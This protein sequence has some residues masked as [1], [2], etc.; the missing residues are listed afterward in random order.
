[1]S[2]SDGPVD[3]CSG[4]GL[5]VGVGVAVVGVCAFRGFVDSLGFVSV[6]V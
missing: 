6:F 4:G 2:G 1:M 5:C 3:R